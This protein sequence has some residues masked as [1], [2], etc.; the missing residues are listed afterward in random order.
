[1]VVYQATQTTHPA[2]PLVVAAGREASAGEALL[3]LHAEGQEVDVVLGLRVSGGRGVEDGVAPGEGDGAGGLAAHPARLEDDG[4]GVAGRAEVDREGRHSSSH[5]ARRRRF[6][7]VRR[8]RD[9]LQHE[10]LWWLPIFLLF[11]VGGAGGGGS[12]RMDHNLLLAD[13]D[14]VGVAVDGLA[15]CDV[16]L[17]SSVITVTRRGRR[18]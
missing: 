7:R 13:L 4:V 14:N 5:R 16:Y 1:M 11:S 15:N 17:V 6:Q 18:T 8:G 10:R 2:V 12:G 3:V 9:G